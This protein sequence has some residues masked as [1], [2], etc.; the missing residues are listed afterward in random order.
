M[1]TG[2]WLR[3][4]AGEHRRCEDETLNVG[5]RDQAL[6]FYRIGRDNRNTHLAGARLVG[7]VRGSAAQPVTNKRGRHSKRGHDE[8][9]EILGGASI[10]RQATHS[11]A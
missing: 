2:L 9:R 11:C 4:S 3:T 10:S 1:S 7:S 5:L 8:L 6:G